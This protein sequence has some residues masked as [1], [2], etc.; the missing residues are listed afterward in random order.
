MTDDKLIA[1]FLTYLKNIKKTSYNTVS[2]YE[3]DLTAFFEFVSLNDKS[4]KLVDAD[5]VERYKK[6]LVNNGKSVATVSRCMSSLRSF[7]KYLVVSG[8]CEINPT[9]EVKNDK[10]EKKYFEIRQCLN[11][12]M[13]PA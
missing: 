4:L 11:C 3:R 1:E 10:V 2:A 7:Y 12:F 8:I 9:V 6:V 13:Q 5:F